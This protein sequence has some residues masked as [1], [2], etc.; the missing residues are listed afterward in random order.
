MKKILTLSL[1]LVSTVSFSQIEG[2]WKLADQAAAL[3]VG[4]GQGNISWWSNSAGDVTTRACL[5]DDSITFAGGNMT[6]YMNGATWLET[7]Q[8]VAADGCGAPIAPHDGSTAATYTY[9]AT[10]GTLTVNGLGAHIGLAKAFNGGELT[11]PAGAVSTITYLVTFSNGGNN[12]TAD[13]EIAGGG[14]WRF[15]YQKTT[16]VSLPDPMVTFSVDM[17]QYT[18]TIGTAVNLSG[19]FNNWCGDCAPMT[20]MG[21][22][23]WELEVELPVGDIEYKFSVD[24]WTDSDQLP[25]GGSCIDPI[26]DG[27]DNRFYSVAG[28]ATLPIVCFNSCAACLIGLDE[29]NEGLFQVVPNPANNEVAVNFEGNAKDIVIMDISG[30]VVKTINN[31]TSGS[32]IDVSDFE[33]GMFMVTSDSQE[34]RFSSVLVIE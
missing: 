23:I 26:A 7:W 22:G 30:R 12:M 6:H 3:G 19:T 9:D 1:L 29:L 34:G 11:S 32:T 15:Q 2:T 24:N 10:A 20:N 33:S 14:F 31:Y 27:F 25:A 17:S 16:A 18:G 28:D 13:I 4:P 8:G 21:N 5:F